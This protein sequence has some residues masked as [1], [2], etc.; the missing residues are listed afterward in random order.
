MS[1]LYYVTLLR[2]FGIS[3]YAH[4]R[5]GEERQSIRRGQGSGGNADSKNEIHP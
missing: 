2:D 5:D 4:K 3:P 1:L